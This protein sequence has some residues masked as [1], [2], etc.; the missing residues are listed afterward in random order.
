MIF[1][2]KGQAALEFLTTY[3]WAFL[4][5]LVM[6]GG[7]AYFGVFNFTDKLPDS[8]SLD[9]K[10]ACGSVYVLTNSG[11]D[12]LQMQIKNNDLTKITIKGASIIE[13][14]IKDSGVECNSINFT[15]NS[16]SPDA[17]KDVQFDMANLTSCGI[18]DNAG[19][20]RLSY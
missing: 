1:N 15:G 2:K 12:T 11:N 10:L 20:K 5:I 17:M 6:I 3:G 18:A 16:I 14:S 8:C 9:G 13:K 19:Q 4:V 7:L